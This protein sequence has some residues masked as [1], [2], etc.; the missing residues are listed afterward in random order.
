M[1]FY[2]KCWRDRDDC[3]AIECVIGTKDPSITEEDLIRDDKKPNSFVCSG[4]IQE[5]A[6]TQDQDCYR[7]CFKSDAHGDGCNVDEMSDN[8]LQDLTSVSNVISRTLLYDAVVK[9][10]NGRMMV[11]TDDDGVKFVKDGLDK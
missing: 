8:D 3:E 10:N 9:R 11:P 4:L 2:G 7:L 6:R 1:Q 5:S